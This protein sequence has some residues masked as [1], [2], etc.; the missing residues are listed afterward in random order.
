M[1]KPIFLFVFTILFGVLKSQNNLIVFTSTGEPFYLVING[2]RY[3]D[4]PQTNVK[5]EGILPSVVQAKII[6]ENK[7][8]DFDIKLY[9]TY[10]GR[11]TSNMEFTY[12]IVRKKKKYKIKYI[13][14]TKL[15][16]ATNISQQ[17]TAKAFTPLQLNLPN[18][19]LS[20]NS[21]ITVTPTNP[22]PT[23]ANTSSNPCVT[24]NDLDFEGAKKSVD[25]K[26]L[27][28]DKLIIAKE[29]TNKKCLTSMQVQQLMRLMT[30]ETSKLE[31]A[32]YAYKNCM[33]KSN[34]YKVNDAFGYESTISDLEAF[35][36]TQK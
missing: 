14:S 5:A 1:T 10:E 6:F 36:K 31:L 28:D 21:G 35:L 13:S 9:L 22:T 26:T 18:I 25:S 15:V 30:Y 16:S 2:S 34:Y 4:K 29:I 8:P 20:T 24:I 17:D 12:S 33:D 19:N 32:K 27:E 11:D 7:K 3:N 23:S